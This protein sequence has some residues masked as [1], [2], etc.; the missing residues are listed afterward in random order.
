MK[1]IQIFI[2]STYPLIYN[3]MQPWKYQ[4][5]LRLWVNPLTTE[6]SQSHRLNTGTTGSMRQGV[7]FYLQ[8]CSIKSAI[9][10]PVKEIFIWESPELFIVYRG[11][12]KLQ[13]QISHSYHWNAN[14][15]RRWKIVDNHCQR[16]NYNGSSMCIIV[17]YPGCRGA[18]N[19]YFIWN[20]MII[21]YPYLFLSSIERVV[22]SIEKSFIYIFLEPEG[23]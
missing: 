5:Y 8:V 7:D 12:S 20:W 21:C 23:H 22:T 6:F 15:C 4:A 19:L 9:T 3:P 13:P 11:G 10:C 2:I 14:I 1:H 18:F 17:F 16:E